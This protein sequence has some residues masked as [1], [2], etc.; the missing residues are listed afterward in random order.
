M[1]EVAKGLVTIDGAPRKSEED[2]SN[3]WQITS[4]THRET[5][6]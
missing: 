2:S 6:L 5:Y 1:K 3:P 4:D